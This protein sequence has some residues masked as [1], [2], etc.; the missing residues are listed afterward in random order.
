MIVVI[1]EINANVN[2][3]KLRLVF[4]SI[5][6]EQNEYK[7]FIVCFHFLWQNGI[8][9]PILKHSKQV[10]DILHHLGHNETSKN[11]IKY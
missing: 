9:V 6:K 7:P 10:K 1:D 8:Y 3:L 4:V 5:V 11:K 2:L